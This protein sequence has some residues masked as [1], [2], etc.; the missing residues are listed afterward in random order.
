MDVVLFTRIR[1]CKEGTISLSILDRLPFPPPS[2]FGIKPLRR[3]K[4]DLGGLYG[5]EVSKPMM[6][7]GMERW[8]MAEATWRVLNAGFRGTRMAPNFH[9]SYDVQVS[10]FS[11]GPFILF[12]ILH[13]RLGEYGNEKG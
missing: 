6:R 10:I 8:F 12:R 4:L 9:F 3:G 13:L 1:F 5:R 2:R 7:C 11:P